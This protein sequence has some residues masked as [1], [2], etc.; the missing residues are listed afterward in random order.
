[1]VLRLVRGR[2]GRCQVF[3][4]SPLSAFADL[5]KPADAVRGVLFISIFHAS[6]SSQRYWAGG[7]VPAA[8]PHSHIPP[9]TVFFPH[10]KSAFR[11][12]W[13]YMQVAD[14]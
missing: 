11:M 13:K 12:P 10:D 7:S 4:F 1:M 9:F 8:C 14:G 6:H 3:L 2:V 5:F